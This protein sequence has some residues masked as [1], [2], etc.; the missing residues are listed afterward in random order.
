[1]L[2]VMNKKIKFSKHLM[3]NFLFNKKLIKL[4]NYNRLNNNSLQSNIRKNRPFYTQNLILPLI[5]TTI[6]QKKNFNIINF[7]LLNAKKKINQNYEYKLYFRKYIYLFNKL[8]NLLKN[9]DLNINLIY[10]LKKKIKYF[11]VKNKTILQ[12]NKKLIYFLKH[13]FLNYFKNKKILTI[14]KKNINLYK[15]IINIECSKKKNFNYNK[16]YIKLIG[17]I[18]KNGNKLKAKQIIKKVLYNI[19][20]DIKLP[21][22][23]ILIK[24]ISKLKLSIE[25]RNIRVRRTFHAVPVPVNTK[26][27]F[28]LITKLILFA[29]TKSGLKRQSTN[30]KLYSE[31]FNLLT[32]K[33]NK[34][35]DTSLI[36]ASLLKKNENIKMAL[37]NKANMHFRW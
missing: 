25:T 24:L 23:T 34:K 33:L 31:F 15:N 16:L 19:Q 36:P 18:T 5:N 32:Q 9:K 4:K 13:T 11:I 28:Y 29:I 14:K 30:K 21:I 27:S 1:M 8:L 10:F 2:P 20:K 12:I 6:K 35:S 22:N 26:R 37:A 17:L 7:K 3:K